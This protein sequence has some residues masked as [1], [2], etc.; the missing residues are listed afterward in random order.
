MSRQKQVIIAAAVVVGVVVLGLGAAWGWVTTTASAELGRA[1]E[2]H[3]VE[4][5]VPWPLSEEDVVELRAQARDRLLQARA[6]L[7]PVDLEP[8]DRDS[9][10][11]QEQGLSDADTAPDLTDEELGLDLEA[12]AL[13]RALGRGRYLIKA[14]YPCGECHGHDLGG[15]TMVDDPMV[16]GFFGPNLTGGQGSV[17]ADYTTADWDRIL[18]HGVKADGRVAMMPSVDFFAMSDRELS[19]IIATIR[20]MPAVDREAEPLRLGPLGS[21]LI[22][23]G[24][25]VF[26]ADQHP[27]HHAAHV[28]APP[29]AEDT[30][31]YG[32]HI[33][34]ACAGCH[35]TSFT[36][37]P[38]VG[39]PPDW[40]EASNLTP[41]SEG[42]EGWT[43]EDFDRAMLQG[44]RPGGDPLRPPMSEVSSMAREMT[45]VDRRAMYAYFMSLQPKP[46]G[47]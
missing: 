26:S 21:V 27:D 35:Q 18:R 38:V 43:F 37:G 2:V 46:T 14:R 30:L 22:A 29:P 1:V 17:V 12:V 44:L 41:H 34:Q 20:T 7:S 19:D 36:G 4:L 32:G 3:E 13:E 5:A 9:A 8:A 28:A 45:E 25:F 33:A 31:A 16:G 15:G 24:A 23:T 6:E 40:P 42:L 11:D 47:H 10:E 39:A